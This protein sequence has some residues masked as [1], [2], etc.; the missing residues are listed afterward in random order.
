MPDPRG[1]DERR[2][3]FLPCAVDGERRFQQL[4][5]QFPARLRDH[6]LP[7]PVIQGRRLL[8]CPGQ[9]G[10]ELLHRAGHAAA[11]SSSSGPA[12]VL[13]DL[14]VTETVT[15]IAGP[16]L[17]AEGRFPPR[18]RIRPR[19]GRTR[20]PGTTPG[21]APATR[22][23]RHGPARITP[24]DARNAQKSPDTPSLLTFRLVSVQLHSYWKDAPGWASE[25]INLVDLNVKRE[26]HVI[27]HQFEARLIEQVDDVVTRA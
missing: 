2:G 17:P 12:P 4:P 27:P 21:P 9:H 8:R 7:V 18:S 5:L 22:L 10:G 6:F 25:M 19:N 11:S 14:D 15:V 16:P 20:Q 23:H 26:R 3:P 13:V 24:S 1:A